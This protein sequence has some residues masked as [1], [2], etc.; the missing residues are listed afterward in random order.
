[1][2]NKSV[3]PIWLAS[4]PKSGNTWLRLFLSAL[5][6]DKSDINEIETDGIIS[7]RS[8][9][10]NFLGINS[11]DIPEQDFLKY[12][13]KLYHNWAESHKNKDYLLCKV[14]DACIR[15]S[16]ILFPPAITRG[17]IYIL[18]NPFDMAAS[19]ANH[20]G[21]SIEGAVK[22]LCNHKFSLSSKTNCLPQQVSQYLG[23]WAYHVE[24]WANVHRGKMLLIK[25]EEMLK[26]P[27]EEFS[28]VAKYLEI[29]HSAEE[30]ESAIMKTSFN[31]LKKQE[32]V[33]GFIE[34]SAKASS[35]FRSGKIGG[36]RNEITAQ[37]ADYIIDCN[38]STLLKY[39]YIDSN[40][41]ILI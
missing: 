8:I 30:I 10:D 41:N 23:T 14:H 21:L 12:R 2:L 32:E 4:Y 16:E 3:K 20:H 40:D 25:Y 34:T 38:Y 11:A 24:S 27:F 13:T 28:K 6:K 22:A 31:S 7:S 35:F 15:E 17:T 39:Q 29:S 26:N 18:R 9:I 1:M 37:Q 33:H 36:W 19:L 5:L